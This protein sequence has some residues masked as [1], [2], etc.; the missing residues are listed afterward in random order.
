MRHVTNLLVTIDVDRVIRDYKN[1][2]TN[3]KKP[4]GLTQEYL[5]IVISDNKA[6]RGERKQDLKLSAEVGDRIRVH[7]TSEYANFGKSLLI[8]RIKKFRSGDL[9]GNF[10]SRKYTKSTPQPSGANVLPPKNVDMDFC[11]Y[12]ADVE[13]I[14][15]AHYQIYFALYVDGNLHGY[16]S[17]DHLVIKIDK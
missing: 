1:P 10:N 11:F 14:G 8:Y 16:F 12:E 4:T 17:W 9:L 7:G 5:Y 3:H 13:N 2:S 6:I 15:K